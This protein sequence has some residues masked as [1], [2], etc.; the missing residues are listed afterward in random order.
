MNDDAVITATITLPRNFGPDFR[1]SVVVDIFAARKMLAPIDFPDSD[2][3]LA[4]MFCTPGAE[5][6]LRE[7]KEVIASISKALATSLADAIGAKDTIMGYPKE[8]ME[9]FHKGPKGPS[10]V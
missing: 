3:G 9:E 4:V 1:V 2:P 10:N 7:R 5:L 6:K 8:F